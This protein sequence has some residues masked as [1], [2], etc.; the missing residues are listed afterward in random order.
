MCLTGFVGFGVLAELCA[1]ARKL[2]HLYSTG[3]DAV[4]GMVDEIS[5]PPAMIHSP[6]LW[7]AEAPHLYCLTM[8]LRERPTLELGLPPSVATVASSDGSQPSRSRV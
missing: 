4:R 1:I 8:V 5:L 6:K 7:S 2:T 3:A